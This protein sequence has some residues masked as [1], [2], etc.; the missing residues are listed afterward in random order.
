M[1]QTQAKHVLIAV[2]GAVA[3]S[4]EAAGHDALAD[5]AGDIC[6]GCQ[7]RLAVAVHHALRSACAGCRK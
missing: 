6:G 5:E 1:D 4:R 3:A 2:A 7:N